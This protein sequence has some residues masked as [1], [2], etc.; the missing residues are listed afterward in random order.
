MTEMEKL[1]DGYTKRIEQVA[2]RL[3]ESERDRV[4]EA[5]RFALEAHDGQLRRSGEPYIMHPVAVAEIAQEIGLDTDSIVAAL[6]HDVI[7]DT[8]FTFEDVKARF[9]EHIA[10]IV[11]GVSKLTRVQYTYKEDEQMENLRKMFLAMAKDIRVILIKIAD[12]LHNMRTAQYWSDQKRR[13]KALE[14]MEI[15]APLAHRLGMQRVKWELEDIALRCLDPVGYA[16]ITEKVE[17]VEHTYQGF[18]ENVQSRISAKL[19]E[20][21]VKAEIYGRVKHVYSI[22]RKMYNQHK[23]L[24]EI[25]DLYAVRVIV[26]DVNDCYNVLGVVHDLYKPMPGRFKDYISTP[27]P[28]MYQSL[29]TTVIGREGMPFEVQIRTWE[30]HHTAEYGIA[31]H[32][33]YKEGVQGDG[34]EADQ[35]L[36]WVRRLLESQEDTD[37]DEFLSNLKIDMFADEVFV[38]TPR[39]DVI[40]LP[41][42]ATPIDFAYAIHTGVGNRMTGVRVG[43]RMVGYDYQLQ[44]GD[45]VE[46]L[47]SKVERGP[48]R[49]WLEL[50]KTSEARNKIRQWFKKEKR[51]ENIAE[52]KARFEEQ[53]QKLNISPS[54]LSGDVLEPVLRRVSFGSLEEM[55]AAIG[56]GG[57]TA[58]RAANRVRD[59]LARQGKLGD[60]TAPPIPAAEPKKR[61]RRTESGVV[62]EGVENC[63]V[64]FSRCCTPVPGDEIVGFVTRGY[65]VS[66]HRRDCQNVAALMGEH[67]RGRW[68]NVYWAEEPGEHFTTGLELSARDRNNLVVDVMNVLSVQHVVVTSMNARRLEDGFSA[69]N[70]AIEVKDLA[71]LK[72]VMGK[73]NNIQGIIQVTRKSFDG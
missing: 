55:Y 13:E 45:I 67:E 22:Y 6:L 15:Y 50:A 14:T 35:K 69:I 27:K 58:M 65:G 52:G 51:E 72:L 68:I 36:E 2:A 20:M 40:N 43:G 34:E 49:G 47:T 12:R 26:D 3:P 39:G 62:V 1:I 48:S 28:N 17:E 44:N 18:L 4:R 60:K 7:E 25:Y 24:S 23:S 31:A 41:A 29:H 73:L 10:M 21:G 30:M 33:K 70:L 56:Y 5:Y 71:M 61:P 54:V 42:G 57:L 53:L 11:D 32:W 63:M 38:F 8:K 46:I 66:V 37:A 9:G 19:K 16:E 64:K 59:E